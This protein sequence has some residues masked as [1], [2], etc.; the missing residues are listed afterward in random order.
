[1]LHV[2]PSVRFQPAMQL[3]LHGFA[4]LASSKQQLPGKQ[5]LSC[6]CR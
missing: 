2:Y 4:L 1:M 3:L 5:L 6:C